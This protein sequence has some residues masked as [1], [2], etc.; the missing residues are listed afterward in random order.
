MTSQGKPM[1]RHPRIN[2]QI[3]PSAG[4][5]LQRDQRPQVGSH[6]G[7]SKKKA[8]ALDVRWP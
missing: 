6:A 7:R 2:R 8:Q 5:L 1:H 3:A 4:I